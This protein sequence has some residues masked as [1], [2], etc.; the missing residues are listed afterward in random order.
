MSN[1]KLDNQLNLAIN[2]SME[3]REKSLD[4]NVGFD[5]KGNV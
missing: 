2:A 3:E 4:L 1:Q 5:E